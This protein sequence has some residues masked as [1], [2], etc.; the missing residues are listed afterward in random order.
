MCLAGM[1]SRRMPLSSSTGRRLARVS[2]IIVA[3]SAMLEV[4][5]SNAL[6]AVAL[7]ICFTAGSSLERALSLA[8][9]HVSLISM[10]LLWQQRGFQRDNE[11]LVQWLTTN[12]PPLSLQWHLHHCQCVSTTQ[13]ELAPRAAQATGFCQVAETAG[14]EHE[15][16]MSSR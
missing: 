9:W 14:T 3:S 13:H 1:A 4:T 5:R 11:A 15:S 7:G 2:T 8:S 12:A 6:G 16:L 10:W